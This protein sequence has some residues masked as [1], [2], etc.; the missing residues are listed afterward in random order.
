MHCETCGK[1][2]FY[3]DEWND[4]ACPHCGEE[5]EEWTE[6]DTEMFLDSLN[7]IF[8]IMPWAMAFRRSNKSGEKDE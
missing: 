4:F 6:E 3:D 1:I 2:I 8:G 5:Y 7:L